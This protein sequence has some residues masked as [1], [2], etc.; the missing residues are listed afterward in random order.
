MIYSM[1]GYGRASRVDG[2]TEISVE[3]RSVNSRFLDVNSRLIRIFSGRESE[4]KELVK[5][6]LDRGKVN[7]DV[8]VIAPETKTREMKV[9]ENA[10]NVYVDLLKSVAKKAGIKEDLKIEDLLFFR[11][12]F[13]SEETNNNFDELWNRV[14]EV[15][16]EGLV[17]LKAMRK[18]EGDAIAGDLKDRMAII[19][20]RA[21]QIATLSENNVAEEHQKFMD[22]IQTFLDKTDLD[23]GRLELE[24]AIIADKIDIS[25]EL[26]R[27]KSHLDL[28]TQAMDSKQQDVGKK[29]NFILQEMNREVNTI[30]S[31]STHVEI[32][33]H[34]VSM[35][36]EIEKLREQVQ[37]I[38]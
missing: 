11:D 10:V 3:I 23:E 36:E 18:K 37:N 7:I 2:E 6:H 35:K 32:I 16:E 34:A 28:F 1:T 15:V 27:L 33:H 5:K 29:L 21:G 24:L 22:R 8:T 4:L 26:T 30:S 17:D 13:L 9:D 31:K 14:V 38:E 25:E 12:I 19:E 20:S